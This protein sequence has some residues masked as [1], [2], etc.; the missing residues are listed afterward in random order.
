MEFDDGGYLQNEQPGDAVGMFLRGHEFD[1]NEFTLVS[2][3]G[4]CASLENL[5]LR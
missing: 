1:L 4:A 3:F 2:L 5:E